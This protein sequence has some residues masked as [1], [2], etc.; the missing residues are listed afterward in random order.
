MTPIPDSPHSHLVVQADGAAR[1]LIGVDGGGTGTRVR[2]ADLQ[3]RILGQGDAGPSALGQG[4]E[5]AWRHIQQ[6]V[7]AAAAQAGL[8]G[9]APIDCAIGLG[10]SGAGVP[11]QAAEFLARQ[12]GYALLALDNDGFTTVLGAHAGQPGA[13]VASGTGSVGEV[14]RRDGSRGMA[15]GWGWIAGDEGSGAWLGLKAMRHACQA[16]DGRVPA[17][18]L[19]RAV[20]AVAGVHTEAMLAWGAVAGQ[21]AY[22]SLA[23]LVFDC[24]DNDAIAAGFLTEAVFELEKLAA[25]LDPDASLPLA[26]CGS[27]ALR[28]AP[29]FSG[30]LRARCVSPQGDSADGGLHLVRG[31]LQRRES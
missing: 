10:L 7:E 2:L 28:L 9:L 27:I 5:Q 14:L 18:S 13:V 24:A 26:L 20:W 15:G 11:S 19:A 3:G 21:H 29:N 23:P 30:A 17:G 16:M 4:S 25:A 8:T 6:A 22:A 1:F 12:P 31:A